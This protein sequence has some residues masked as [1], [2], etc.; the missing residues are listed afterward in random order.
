M[1]KFCPEG[2]IILLATVTDMQTIHPPLHTLYALYDD[3]CSDDDD[4]EF[5]FTKAIWL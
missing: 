5:L 3:S 4:D 1:Y 2:L